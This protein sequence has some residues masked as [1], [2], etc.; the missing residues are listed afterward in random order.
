[1]NKVIVSNEDALDAISQC[2]TQEEAMELL[3]SE[4]GSHAAFD[5]KFWF[6]FY[7]LPKNAET[8][9]VGQSATKPTWQMTKKEYANSG[10]E[11]S[12][13]Y[14]RNAIVIAIRKG[15]PVPEN[16][17]RDYPDLIKK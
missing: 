3:K 10:N 8:S 17:L 9:A 4:F 15:E 12:E 5:L 13:A 6:A 1:M 2:Q 16:V 7:D 11:L 14:H